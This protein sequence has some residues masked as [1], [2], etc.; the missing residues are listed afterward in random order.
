M[1]DYT[2]GYDYGVSSAAGD[3]RTTTQDEQLRVALERVDVLEAAL[4]QIALKAL[5]MVDP[6]WPRKCAVRALGD[7]AAARLLGTPMGPAPVPVARDI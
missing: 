3:G 2:E 5:P 7:E 6:W 4:A 1:K